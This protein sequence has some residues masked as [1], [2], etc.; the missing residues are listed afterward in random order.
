M[1][2]SPFGSDGTERSERD[3]QMAGTVRSLQPDL[4]A[5]VDAVG[6]AGA[7]TFGAAALAMVD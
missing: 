5:A 6:F 2:D 3:D 1:R 7:G 4:L